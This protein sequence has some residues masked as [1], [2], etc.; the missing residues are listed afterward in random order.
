MSKP[1]IL[2]LALAATLCACDE[3]LVCPQGQ[4]ECGSRCVSLLTDATSCGACGNACGP[5]EVC[6]AGECGCAP[7]ME[8]CGGA[9]ADVARDPA[10]CGACGNACGAGAP[11]CDAGPDAA[12]VSACGGGRTA[13]AG[14]CVELAADPFHCGACGNACAAGEACRGGACASDLFVACFNTTEVI[15]VS[16]DLAPA[17]A[18]RATPGGPIALTTL[19][20]AV[21]SANNFPSAGVSV[22]PVDAA[23][24]ITTTPLTAQ[25][26]DLQ[27]I[28]AVGG[29]LVVTNA[30]AGTLVFLDPLGAVVDELALPNQQEYPNPKELGVVGDVAYVAL[31]GDGPDSGQRVARVDLSPLATCRETGVCGE[32][33][34]ELDV[35]SLPGSADAPGLPFPAG[36]ATVDGRV[37]VTLTNLAQECGDF[38]CFYS[39]PAGSGKLLVIDAA[40]E[41][42]A[43]VVDL[44]AGCANPTGLAAFSGTLWVTCGAVF[45]PDLAPGAIV[46][47]ELNRSPL[48]P[49]API[50]LA[51][52][53]PGKLAFCGG[54]GY[55]GDQ[56]TGDVI[57]FDPATR[58]FGEP[59][60]ICP[61]GPFGFTSVSDIACTE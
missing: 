60:P 58:T 32:L 11:L 7:G 57:R 45:Y 44:G 46:T 48:A 6:G 52:F 53:V 5:L 20:A 9:C 16:A 35:A 59:A 19:G 28:A 49:S 3:E 55:V 36:V 27:F 61:T 40:R 22:I 18:S 21:Y 15:P 43:T 1:S 47:L 39:R 56:A 31:S 33:A 12:C 8:T 29:L 25:N 51:P 54:V 10:N 4:T 37:F 26:Q 17:G 50:P 2:A 13:C 34:G 42:A 38:G 41:D 23:R 30:D 24:P 14:A